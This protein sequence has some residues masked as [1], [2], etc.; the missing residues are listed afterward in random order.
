MRCNVRGTLSLAV[1]VLSLIF[2]VIV[3]ASGE[4]VTPGPTATGTASS[5]KAHTG[6]SAPWGFVVAIVAA[7]VIFIVGGLLIVLRSRRE[8]LDEQARKAALS[9][10]DD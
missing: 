10:D 3:A 9:R 4:V 8:Y 1:I 7:I 5:I 2:G 6:G